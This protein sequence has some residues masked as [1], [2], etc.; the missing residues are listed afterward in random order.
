MNQHFGNIAADLSPVLWTRHPQCSRHAVK[1][2]RSKVM[3][4]CFKK[5][6]DEVSDDLVLA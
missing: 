5:M 2:G 4:S 1:L 3:H 6:I